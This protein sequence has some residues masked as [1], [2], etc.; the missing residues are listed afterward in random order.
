MSF[1]RVG[2]IFKA[3]NFD[4]FV[5]SKGKGLSDGI[6]VAWKEERLNLS[7][8]ATNFQFMHSNFIDFLKENWGENLAIDSNLQALTIE[9]KRWNK[10]VFR[11][12]R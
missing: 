4:K 12:I 5:V 1:E 6:Q 2:S 10:E 11:D 8:I 3:L 7:L 9:L